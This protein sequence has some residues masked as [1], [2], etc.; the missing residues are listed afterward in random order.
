MSADNRHPDDAH[1]PMLQLDN[2]RFVLF[3]IKHDNLWTFFKKA[4]A[5]FWTA[6]EID[7]AGDMNDWESLTDNE[8][9]FLT[10]VLAFFAASDGVVNENLVEKFSSE[11]QYTEAKF[12]YGS[13]LLQLLGLAPNRLLTVAL[14]KRADFRS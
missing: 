1:E 10:H 2:S 4:Q 7:L 14:A 9:H 6:E 11:V 3:P 8:R 5:S 13:A 12:F